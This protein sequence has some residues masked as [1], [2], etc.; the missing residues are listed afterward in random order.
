MNKVLDLPEEVI[1]EL[2]NSFL[3]KASEGWTFM[4]DLSGG[5]GGGQGFSKVVY[6]ND[7]TDLSMMQS[8][9]Y[10]CLA[11][12]KSLMDYLISTSEDFGKNDELLRLRV[13]RTYNYPV[14][15]DEDYHVDIPKEVNSSTK[16]VV[17][18]LNDVGK[19]RCGTQYVV[20]ETIYK[21]YHKVGNCVLLSGDTLHKR[22]FEDEVKERV[23]LNINIGDQK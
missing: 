23:V 19:A 22:F 18:Y 3:N 12:I 1:T 13:T 2:S 14:G 8:E 9:D 7:V 20:G 15:V 11:S 21:S 17:V 16:T 6:Q 4:P 5:F 10:D